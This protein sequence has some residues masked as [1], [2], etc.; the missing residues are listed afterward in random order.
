[1]LVNIGDKTREH[2]AVLDIDSFPFT[3]EELSKK[4]KSKIYIAH[5][6]KGGSSGEAR[7]VLEARA[8]LKNMVQANIDRGSEVREHVEDDIFSNPETCIRCSGRGY[9][10]NPQRRVGGPNRTCSKCNG[11]GKVEREMFNPVIPKG[12]IL[13]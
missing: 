4:F 5:E 13:F 6:D 3:E 1:M 8:F 11:K 7:K 9:H 10:F 12:A 2:M